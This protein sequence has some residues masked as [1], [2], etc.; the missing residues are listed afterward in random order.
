MPWFVL[1]ALLFVRPPQAGAQPADCVR[2][3]GFTATIPLDLQLQGLPGVPRGLSGYVGADV[4]AP[5]PGGFTCQATPLPPSTDALAG[6]PARSA[7]RVRPAV[8]AAP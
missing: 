3:P 7:T 8:R 4:P 6:P 5:P 2:E 1:F